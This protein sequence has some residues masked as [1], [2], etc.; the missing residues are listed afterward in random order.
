MCD[1]AHQKEVL[2]L[3]RLVCWSVLEVFVQRSPRRSYWPTRPCS[4]I[5]HNWWF[6]FLEI[7][8]WY[9]I[10]GLHVLNSQQSTLAP[11]TSI[12]ILFPY[13]LFFL[14]L[15]VS[16]SFFPSHSDGVDG[17]RGGGLPPHLP[18]RCLA[19]SSSAALVFWSRDRFLDCWL[20]HDQG[21]QKGLQGVCP[22]QPTGSK[23][24]PWLF[25]PF[26]HCPLASVCLT[27]CRSACLDFCLF[28]CP[29]ISRLY[30]CLSVSAVCPS[31][32]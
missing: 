7:S 31:I 32:H 12:F 6:W 20:E 26:I 23:P 24:S 29:R 11:H 5:T 22:N 16:F 18:G 8:I 13:S 27:V 19:T 9:V 14:L 3:G 15:G 25:S 4:W 17:G 10:T 1:N 21:L 2:S 30:V 28:V